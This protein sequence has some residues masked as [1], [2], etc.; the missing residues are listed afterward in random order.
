MKEAAWYLCQLDMRLDQSETDAERLVNASTREFI[1]ESLIGG[2]NA[3][4]GFD[5]WQ[6][7]AFHD[8]CISDPGWLSAVVLRDLSDQGVQE[9]LG[10]SRRLVHYVQSRVS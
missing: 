3:C 2:V 7:A 10:D 8:K 5:S 9:A 4:P 6:Y 1:V